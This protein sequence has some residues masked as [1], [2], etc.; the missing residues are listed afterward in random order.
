MARYSIILRKNNANDH[1]YTVATRLYLI[2][3]DTI[4]YPLFSD[5]DTGIHPQAAP[6]YHVRPKA[7]W[8]IYSMLKCLELIL[9]FINV[10]E[11]KQISIS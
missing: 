3:S 6:W 5:A 11:V 1:I 2:V 4:I 7:E 8:H 9:S 10:L